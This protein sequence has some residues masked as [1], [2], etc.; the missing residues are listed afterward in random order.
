MLHGTRCARICEADFGLPPPSPHR[1]Y[2]EEVA[3]VAGLHDF[4]LCQALATVPRERFLPAGPWTI[5]RLGGT[6]Y[7]SPDADI[8]RILHAVTVILDEG[9]GIVSGN[10]ARIA[11]QIE[12]ASPW[13]GDTVLHAGAGL[14]YYSALLAEL[15][16]PG[17]RVIAAEIDPD[18][19]ARAMD[20]LADYDTVTVIGD[21]LELD[22]PPLDVVF[23]SAGLTA[24]PLPWARA[25]RPG[26]RMVLPLT[27][28]EMCG[29][30]FLFVKSADPAWFSA[31]TLGFERYTPFRH[32]RP[33]E[34]LALDAALGRASGETVR[35]LRLDP[36]DPEPECWL[37]GEGWCLSRRAPVPVIDPSRLSASS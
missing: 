34:A 3:V 28:R 8:A 35:A 29:F 32:R 15:V 33:E 12:A 17:G 11:P 5:E 19:R 26:G 22:P 31:R 27:G 6:R 7:R 23:A 2:A 4:A 18:L 37:H 1:R 9:Q 14:G 20:N 10:P 36:H 30:V 16:G 13:P 21:S 24:V 25:L